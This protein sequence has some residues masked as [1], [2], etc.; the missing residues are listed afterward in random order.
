MTT[1]RQCRSVLAAIVSLKRHRQTSIKQA[2]DA[3]ALPK[4][5][6][7]RLPRLCHHAR[8]ASS[9]C[10]DFRLAASLALPHFVVHAFHTSFHVHLRDESEE[11]RAWNGST[12]L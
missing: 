9:L 5:Q 1:Q 11:I 2:D 10:H 12:A 3:E 6:R 7:R 4:V 8:F